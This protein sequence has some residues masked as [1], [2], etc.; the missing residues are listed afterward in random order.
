MGK[1]EN[2]LFSFNDEDSSSNGKMILNKSNE[3]IIRVV[4]DYLLINSNINRLNDI[5]KR[6]R[7]KIPLNVD[8]TEIKEWEKCES[9]LK[10]TNLSQQSQIGRTQMSQATQRLNELTDYID[11]SSNC[12]QQYFSW[13]G[14]DFDR[15]TLDVYLNYTKYFNTDNLHNRLNL[16]TDYKHAFVQFNLRFLRLFDTN[17]SSFVIDW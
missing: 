17:S 6:L 16:I 8:K 11:F 13:C 10:N 2:D 1:I 15:Q 12:S 9:K 5:Y 3:L 14:F 4:D 7:L